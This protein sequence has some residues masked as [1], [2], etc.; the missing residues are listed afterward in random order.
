MP[1]VVALVAAA[2]ILPSIVTNTFAKSSDGDSGD[3]S[4]GSDK[5][6]TEGKNSIWSAKLDTGSYSSLTISLYN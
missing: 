3:N 1:A 4:G 5:S 2:I 6:K